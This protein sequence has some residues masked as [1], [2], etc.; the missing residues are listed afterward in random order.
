MLV[1][2]GLKGMLQTEVRSCELQPHEGISGGDL[3]LLSS[4]KE[5][6]IQEDLL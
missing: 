5:M 6:V 1:D 2:L 4:E 3:N